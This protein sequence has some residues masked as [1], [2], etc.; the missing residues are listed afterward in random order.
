MRQAI[1]WTNDN[2]LNEWQQRAGSSLVKI[3]AC[4]LFDAKALFKPVLITNKVP[5]QGFIEIML[6]SPG[7]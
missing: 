3:M 6:N 1:I 5:G 4:P 7:E 2:L